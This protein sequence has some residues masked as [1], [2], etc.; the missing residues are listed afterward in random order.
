M[1]S[2]ASGV[3]PD[4]RDY[5][6]AT[7]FSGKPQSPH[8]TRQAVA[9]PVFGAFPQGLVAPRRTSSLM[10]GL[11]PQSVSWIFF[12]NCPKSGELTCFFFFF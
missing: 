3:S 12:G 4:T 8:V 7:P 10:T 2:P 9:A 6:Q 5:R 1:A 11:C